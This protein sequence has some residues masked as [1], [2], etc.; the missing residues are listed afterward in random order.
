MCLFNDTD[1]TNLLFFLY[2][3]EVCKNRVGRKR[4]RER[5]RNREKQSKGVRD[6]A[7]ERI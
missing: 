4:K 2:K 3:I 5:E 7:L 6:G 1:H